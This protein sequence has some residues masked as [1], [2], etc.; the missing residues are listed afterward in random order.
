MDCSIAAPVR[1]SA[2]VV[3]VCRPLALVASAAFFVVVGCVMAIPYTAACAAIQARTAPTLNAVTRSDSFIGLGNVP[4]FTLRQSV[5]AEKGSGAGE[6]GRFGL[7]TSCDSRM[8]A[9]SGRAS[10]TE[11]IIDALAA[12][13]LNAIGVIGDVGL[14]GTVWNSLEEAP[15]IPR[16]SL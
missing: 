14:F 7:C 11:W 15:T 5:G 13:M 1:K 12:G 2:L 10:K 16:K 8:K 6:S 3:L 9:L 4:A